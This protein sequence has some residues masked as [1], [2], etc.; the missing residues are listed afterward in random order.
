MACHCC[1]QLPET[2]LKPIYKCLRWN[3]NRT[4]KERWFWEEFMLC[5]RSVF[6][7][8]GGWQI[9]GG[10]SKGVIKPKPRSAPVLLRTFFQKQWSNE[11]HIQESDVQ[12][13]ERTWKKNAFGI[14][15][16]EA[17]DGPQ[18]SLGLSLI[19][20]ET[21]WHQDKTSIRKGKSFSRFYRV[22]VS[23]KHVSFVVKLS[24]A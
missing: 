4:G 19:K 13:W 22:D 10:G 23:L 1:H 18:S 16:W 6:F 2:L 24:W 15:G 12:T 21:E 8:G 9:P 11:T 17:G 5:C 14:F 3:R 7:F 20:G